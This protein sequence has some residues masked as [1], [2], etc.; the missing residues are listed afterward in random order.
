MLA[1]HLALFLPLHKPPA[2]EEFQLPNGLT[3]LLRPVPQSKTVALVLLFNLGEDHDPPGKSGL[4]H[5]VE[6]LFCVAAAGP[7]KARSYEEMARRYPRGSNAQTGDRY[8]VYA[9]VFPTSEV[10]KE[11]ADLAARLGELKITEAD[12]QQELP[13]MQVELTNMFGRIPQLAAMNHARDLLRPS[14]RGGRKGGRMEHLQTITVQEAQNHWQ[15]YYKPRN[16]TLLLVG[17]LDPQLR[18]QITNRFGALPAGEVP[19]LPQEP[20]LPQFATAKEVPSPPQQAAAEVCLGFLAPAPTSEDYP[21]FLLLLTRLQQSRLRLEPPGSRRAIFALLDDPAVLYL[22]RTIP[23]K[24]TGKE[25]LTSL[26]KFVTAV[27]QAP[28]EQKEVAMVIW[29][30]G[31]FLGMSDP[32]PF[33]LAGNPYGVAFALGRCRQLGIDGPTLKKRLEAV[34]D[35]DLQRVAHKVFGPG[36]SVSVIVTPQGKPER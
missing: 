4:A 7:T 6:H 16:A 14:S 29:Q 22:A 2:L 11:L 12:L 26:E 13:R 18:Q 27:V 5:L 8:T 9:V 25:A 28:L 30:Y 20:K 34:T 3:V 33:D 15:R 19:P 32:S 10:E 1:L 21:A 31:R 35:A 17:N 36:K 23:E 24:T